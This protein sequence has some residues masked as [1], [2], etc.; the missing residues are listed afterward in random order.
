MVK[1]HTEGHHCSD[2]GPVQLLAGFGDSRHFFFSP[3]LRR[4]SLASEIGSLH[5]LRG[6]GTLLLL[7][8]AFRGA[9]HILRKCAIVITPS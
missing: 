7:T 4:K 5:W 3:A 9:R 2:F 6:N 1:P 8:D